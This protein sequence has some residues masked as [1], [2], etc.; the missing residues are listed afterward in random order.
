MTVASSVNRTRLAISGYDYDFTFKINSDTDL[1]VYTVEEVA[2]VDVP[3]LLT[4]GTDYEVTIDTVGEGGT[5]QTGSYVLAVWTPAAPSGDEILMIRNIPYTQTA[6][7]PVR[8]GFNESVIEGA[9]D[10]IVMQI[11]QLKELVDYSVTDDP[12]AALDAQMAAETAEAGAEA[13]QVAAEA[14]QTAAE[15][16]RT[17]AEAAADVAIA[18]LVDL[19]TGHHHDGIDSKKVLASDLD[20]TSSYLSNLRA[21]LSGTGNFT[22][23]AGVSLV[24]VSLVGGGG[25]GGKGGDNSGYRCGG[26]G[27]GGAVVL[28]AT[29]PVTAGNN[30]AYSVG[31]GGGAG[32]DGADTTFGTG[33]VITA[34][35]GSDGEDGTDVGTGGEGGAG[36]AA[37]AMAGVST[38]PGVY[39]S[40]AG[41]AGGASVS[42]GDSGGGGGTY[43]GIGGAGGNPGSAPT[44][45]YG[46][47]GGGGGSASG[48]GR[49]GGAGKGG[50]IIIEW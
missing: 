20:M 17:G 40:F 1:L 36:G 38:T 6:D 22:A 35:H 28:R 48:T 16:A 2:G 10:N 44:I 9:L 37:N 15:L 4:L 30:Y 8:G 24:Y 32:L 45:G 26:G 23:P 46:G 25:G 34:L 12:T 29:Y 19:T 5:V 7:I 18:A 39:G 11:Q 43:C 3:T 14:A 13:A 42:T 33:T 47:G 21:Y 49:L 27:G 50:I 31:A 41:G